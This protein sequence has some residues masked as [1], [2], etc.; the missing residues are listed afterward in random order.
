M[1]IAGAQA[2]IWVNNVWLQVKGEE[3]HKWNEHML[4]RLEAFSMP[5]L[6][7]ISNIWSVS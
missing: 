7:A 1:S 5:C 3:R 4:R 2:S 6:Q